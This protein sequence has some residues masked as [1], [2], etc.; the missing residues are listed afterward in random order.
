MEEEEKNNQPKVQDEETLYNLVVE[1]DIQEILKILK[2]N[3][4]KIE[5]IKSVDDSSP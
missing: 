1:G 4:A 2:E 5:F 3:G